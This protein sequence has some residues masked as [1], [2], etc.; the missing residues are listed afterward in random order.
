MQIFH[1]GQV[2]SSPRGKGTIGEFALHAQCPWRIVGHGKI[3]TGSTD[4]FAPPEDGSE[5]NPHDP[6]AGSQL[7][8]QLGALLK[9]FDEATRSHVSAANEFIVKTTSVDSYGSI[10]IEFS[11]GVQ[12]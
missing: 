6:R 10:D 9:G 8:I 12:L 4:L 7:D 5:V 11:G 2:R 3:I 1:F